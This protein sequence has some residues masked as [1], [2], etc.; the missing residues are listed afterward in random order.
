MQLDIFAEPAGSSGKTCPAHSA[1]TPAE[2]LLSWLVRWQDS[3]SLRPATAGETKA[4]R[5]V[6]TDSSNGACWTRSGSD[7]RSGAS[8]CSLSSILETGPI[9]RRYYLSPTACAGILRRAGNR[10][11]DLPSALSEALRQVVDGES[12]PMKRQQAI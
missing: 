8:A 1:A 7:W 2:T 3:N 4:W 5:S 10:G 9:D 12:E 11:R 6:K